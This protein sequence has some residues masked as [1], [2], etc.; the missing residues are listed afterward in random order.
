MRSLSPSIAARQFRQVA[1]FG[2]AATGAAAKRR[3]RSPLVS[4]TL[5][6]HAPCLLP[7]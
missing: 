4:L 3:L 6:Y 7:Q 5:S 1:K 2:C